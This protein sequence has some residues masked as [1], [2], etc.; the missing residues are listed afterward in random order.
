[1]KAIWR[2]FIPLARGFIPL[3]MTALSAASPVVAAAAELRGCERQFEERS[4]GEA[5]ECFAALA[6]LHPD[7]AGAAAYL[8]R[9]FL[10][11]RQPRP[12]IEWLKKAVALEPR[13]SDLH[14][15]LGQAYGIAAERAPIVKQ[16]SLA[17]KAR[18]EFARAVE[19]D[20][21]NL[22]ACEDL[23]EFLIEAPPFLGGSFEQAKLHAADLARRE[24]LRGR[25]AHAAIVQ[26]QQGLAAAEA[27]LQ[28]AAAEFPRDPRPAVALAAAY[29][30]AGQY[31]RAFAA[32]EAALRLDPDNADARDELARA[33]ALSGQRLDQAEDL[34]ARS[35]ARL[36][37]GDAAALSDCHFELGA[38]LER[39]GDPARAREHYQAALRLDPASPEAQKALH[40]LH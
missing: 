27:E 37:A 40:R 4:F 3:A 34:L 21:A 26:R 15:W 18:K 11:R 30:K 28:A 39:R 23:I 31:E 35:L 33:A 8:G 5:Q 14:D 24:P 17:V 7:D 12:A 29:S 16:F 10:A 32:L 1:M 13:R 9:A 22:D 6:A 25:L 20:A 38:V 19:L 2:G 36:P